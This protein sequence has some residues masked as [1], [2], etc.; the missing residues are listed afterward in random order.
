MIKDGKIIGAPLV[1]F[2]DTWVNIQA[3]ADPVKGMVAYDTTNDRFVS[4]NGSWVEFGGGT[5][6]DAIHLSV[7]DEIST[8]DEKVTLADADLLVIEDSEDD[9]AKKKVQVGSLPGGAGGAPTDAPYVTTAANGDLSAENVVPDFSLRGV[10]TPATIPG[11]SIW[12]DA[13]NITGLADGDAITMW[14]D[15]SG[16]QHPFRGV[17]SPHYKTNIINSLP[18]ARLDGGC[19]SGW[20]PNT[21]GIYTFFVVC[22]FAALTNAYSGVVD[23]EPFAGSYGFM[24]KSNGKS[25]AYWPGGNYDGT[26]D[27]TYDTTN[28]N[29]I[30]FVMKNATYD[31]RRNK[32]ADRTGTAANIANISNFCYLGNEASA[33]RVMAGDIAEFILYVG[34]LTSTQV[35]TIEDY[36][37]T[38]YNLGL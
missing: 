28:W 11:L 1:D 26:G 9:G 10:A 2:S 12:L 18:V 27:V 24:I 13:A 36:L 35:T 17:S 3:L 33:S 19:F 37:N 29:I 21:P 32:V 25:S 7:A 8:L 4:Y 22:K 14:P 5:D 16:F 38:K 6:A 34:T 31:T 30:T 20:F 23:P 15:A